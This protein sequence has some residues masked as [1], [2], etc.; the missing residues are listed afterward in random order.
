MADFEHAIQISPKISSSNKKSKTEVW[1]SVDLRLFSTNLVRLHAGERDHGLR[2]WPRA[3]SL[4]IFAISASPEPDSPEECG[5]GCNSE[6]RS[7]RHSSWR[8]PRSSNS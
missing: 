6:W 7:C 5:A 2:P 1:N 4:I 8:Y 3:L